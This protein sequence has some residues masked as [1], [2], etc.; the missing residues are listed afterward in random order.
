MRVVHVALVAIEMAATAE[1]LPAVSSY[2]HQH[3]WLDRELPAPVRAK[4]MLAN[5]TLDEKIEMLHG[6]RGPGVP[7]GPMPCCECKPG[8][9]STEQVTKAHCVPVFPDNATACAAVEKHGDMS[10]SKA[11]D[12]VGKSGKWCS[13]YSPKCAYTGNVLGNP[14]LKIPPMHMNDGPQGFRE[15]V[16][17]GTSTQ[18]PSG[19][20]VAASWDVDV[21]DAWGSAMG[22][23]FFAKGANVQ[24]GPGLC[25]ARV[26]NNGRNFEYISGEDPHL[27]Y[28]LAGPVVRGIQ[29]HKVIAN[30]KHWVHNNQ[31]TN[32]HFVTS[33]VDERTRHELYYRP[34]AGAIDAGVGSVMCRSV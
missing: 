28:T 25:L 33:V 2:V 5:M 7:G 21:M 34:F 24:L 14:R 11:C 12:D 16:Y 27:G 29:R 23:E 32:R 9:S 4:L 22:E 1:T 8:G 30:A 3:P 18:F 19:L 26:P 6:P 20:A 31:E 17:P 15:S 13:F 10:N